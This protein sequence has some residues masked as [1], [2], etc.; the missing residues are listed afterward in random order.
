MYFIGQFSRD[1]KTFTII[2][3]L[4]FF[5]PSILFQHIYFSKNIEIFSKIHLHIKLVIF[6]TFDHL[7]SK[8]QNNYVHILIPKSHDHNSW[9]TIPLRI[10]LKP[11]NLIFNIDFKKIIL[12]LIKIY[13]HSLKFQII[14][15]VKT[16]K[17]FRWSN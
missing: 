5:E 16:E 9:L 13:F 14:H 17:Q 3:F 8:F 2:Q 12:L 7:G 11:L 15:W 1:P 4:K 6:H 10:K